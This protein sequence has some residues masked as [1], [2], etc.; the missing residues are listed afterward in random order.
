MG[1]SFLLGVIIDMGRKSLENQMKYILYAK[2]N[3]GIG[4]SKHEDK[5]KLIDDGKYNFKDGL[6]SIYSYGT[7]DK[8]MQVVRE[9][10]QYLYDKGVS[11]YSLLD[12][13]QGYAEQYLKERLD[14]GYS[15]Y[16]IK[17]ERSALGKIYGKTIEIEL[18]T[19]KTQNINRSRLEVENDKHFSKERNSDLITIA[20][21]TGT[22]RSDLKKMRVTDFFYVTTDKRKQ[23]MFVH[24][25]KSKGGR[26]RI[27][28]V[29]PT[30]QKEVE[31]ILADRIAN[32][33]EK[34]CTKVHS[35]MDVHSYRRSYAKE[36]YTQLSRDKEFREDILQCYPA[37]NENVKSDTYISRKT[38][39]HFDRDSVY[40]ISQCLGHNRLSV[41]VNHY[42][43]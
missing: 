42:L 15:L 17:A 8:Y 40:I 41:S 13:T 9:Y 19:R 14:K 1:C 31:K 39:E 11:K 37:R 24:I 10:S 16:T 7:A 5:Q 18:P 12:K 3:D 6:E 28:L 32:H 38:Q 2:M 26:N 4:H 43:I 30:K 29:E 34:I 36:I 23:Y 27:A 33:Q 21:A 20:T 25:D 35:A 22:R